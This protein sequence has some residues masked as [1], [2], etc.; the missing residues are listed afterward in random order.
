M[1]RNKLVAGN[2]KMQGRQA[3][4][5]A[6]VGSLLA[7]AAEWSGVEMWVAPPLPYLQQV[8]ALLSG[9]TVSLLAQNVS[10]EDDG[11]CTGEVSAGMLADC[12]CMAVIVGHSERRSRYGETDAQVAE[13][14]VRAQ[15]VGLVPVLCVGE[16]LAERDAG[17]TE[18]VVLRQ[19]EAVLQRA[20]V[21]SFANAV[22]A[23]EPVWAIGTGHSAT[24]AQAQAVHVVLR[25]HVAVV[26]PVTAAALRVL[27]GGS[28]KASNAAELFAMPDIDGALV[29]GASLD[30]NEFAAIARA[31]RAA[32]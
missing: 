12:G 24:P 20:G 28:V 22:L 27:Y 21:K 1:R 23:Y 16:T 30:A 14:F 32:Q 29:G 13:K 5:T 15:A 3:G 18:G 10:H 8:G 2:W 6:L 19:L 7:H 4:N 17:Q 31:A 25:E 11:A 26:D 9:S